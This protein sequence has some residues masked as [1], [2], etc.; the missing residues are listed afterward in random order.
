MKKSLETIIICGGRIQFWK[1][2][3]NAIKFYFD[4]LFVCEGSEEERYSKICRGL[5]RIGVEQNG[6]DFPCINDSDAPFDT[7]FKEAVIKRRFYLYENKGES[8]GKYR[9]SYYADAFEKYSVFNEIPNDVP[10]TQIEFPPNEVL[11]FLNGKMKAILMDEN[12]VGG[13]LSNSMSEVLCTVVLDPVKFPVAYENKVNELIKKGF[14]PYDARKTALGMEIP[15]EVYYE[16][17]YGLFAVESDAIECGWKITSPYSQRNIMDMDTNIEGKYI[18]IGYYNDADDL[19]EISD[20]T[21]DEIVDYMAQGLGSFHSSNASDAF[22]YLE[23]ECLNSVLNGTA[24]LTKDM[25]YAVTNTMRGCKFEKNPD[26][27]EDADTGEYIDIWKL[28]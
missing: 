6:S 15:L 14:S 10:L 26:L 16:D 18:H 3:A 27:P 2:P 11:S 21:A 7:E 8:V 17:G 13:E 24:Y 19:V 5:L 1:N 20:K 22:F 23:E 12:N 9:Y 4:G 28:I 25:K